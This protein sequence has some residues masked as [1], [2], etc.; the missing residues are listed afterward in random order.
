[1]ADTT[2]ADELQTLADTLWAERR[3]VEFLL[4]KLVTAKLILA[5]DERRFVAHA[6]DEV[7]RVVESLR[8]FELRR[9]VALEPVARLWNTS[10]D[11]LTL[12]ELAARAPEPLASVFRDHHE[13]FLSLAS[14]I[15][16]TAT[17]NR[18]L[19]SSSLTHVRQTLDALA[20]APAASSTYTASGTHRPVAASP[21]RLDRAL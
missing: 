1:M 2:G 16:E 17:E 10:I 15:E 6:L 8:A 19:A 12:G 9:A 21:F 5:T 20:G 3:V 18:K 4:F 11:D 14:E 13:T 7:E